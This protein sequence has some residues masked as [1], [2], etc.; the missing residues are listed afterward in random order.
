[1]AAAVVLLGHIV[2]NRV[3]EVRVRAPLLCGCPVLVIITD[4]VRVR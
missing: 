2:V 1:M 3:E 4:D